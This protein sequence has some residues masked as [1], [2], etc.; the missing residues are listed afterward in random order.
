MSACVCVALTIRGDMKE[1]SSWHGLPGA[2]LPMYVRRTAWVGD[3]A[4]KMCSR[5]SF[6][7]HLHFDR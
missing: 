7:K 1:M 5:I 4:Y 2:I 3:R 6:D